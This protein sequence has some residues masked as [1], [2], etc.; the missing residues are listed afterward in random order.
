[1]FVY[2]SRFLTRGEV[3][4]DEKPDGAPVDWIYYRQRSSPLAR[5]AWKRF[6]TLLI[7]LRKKPAELLAE[8][9]TKTA[10]RITE[11]QEKDEL[12]CE[13]CDSRDTGLMDEVEAMWNQFAVSQN[14]PLLER[15]WLEQIQHAGALDVVAARNQDGDVLAYHLVL[16]SP[17]RARQLI[18]ISPYKAVPSVA[19]RSA[20]SRANCLVHWHNFLAFKEQGIHEFDFGGW[21]SGATDIRLLGI[22]RFKRSFGGSV[23][24]EYDGEQAMTAK[25][26]ILL[27]A[28]RMLTSLRE[29]GSPEHAAPQKRD[30]APEVERHQTAP[31]LR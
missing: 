12:R 21:Y 5:G 31:A 20:V 25:G 19:W 15:S 10:Q 11:A 2:R 22:N 26:W 1:M 24:R 28:A 13:R 4:F 27:A 30:K 14:T 29:A 6:D 3:W 7:D 17:R 8:M 9:N 18:A 16:L 23:V